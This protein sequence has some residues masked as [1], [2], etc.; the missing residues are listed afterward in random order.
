MRKPAIQLSDQA[1]RTINDLLSDGK[2]VSVDVNHK[3]NELMIR[4]EHSKLKYRVI[5]SEGKQ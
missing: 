3:T 4:E 2:R 1:V 5:V